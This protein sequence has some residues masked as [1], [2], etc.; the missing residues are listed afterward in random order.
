MH[1]TSFA[2]LRQKDTG[3][4]IREYD[5]IAK[6]TTLGLNFYRDELARRDAELQAHRIEDLT[7]RLWWLTVVI[8]ILTA[9]S[10]FA[11]AYSVLGGG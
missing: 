1:A 6:H 4:L 2:E 7:T 3:K 8:A 10:T 5:D 11:V 9:V